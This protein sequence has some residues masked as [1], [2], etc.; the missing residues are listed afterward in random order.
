M[1]K[2]MLVIIMIA[3]ILC[4]CARN[5]ENE[6]REAIKQSQT[7]TSGAPEVKLPEP[8]TTDKVKAAFLEYINYRLYLYPVEI[9][10]SISDKQFDRYVGKSIDVEI[11]VYNN[12]QGKGVYVSTNVGEW[13]AV[14][15]EKKG[16]IYCDGLIGKN[17]QYKD[18]KIWP[19][20]LDEYELIEKYSV[21]VPE[22]RKPEYGKSER[23]DKMIAA[24][25]A[26]I[27]TTLLDSNTGEESPK[28]KNVVVYIA[29]FYEYENGAHAWLIRQD[30]YIA[31]YPVAFEEKDGRF[32]VIGCKG[33]HM[34]SINNFNE[35]GRFQYDRDIKDAVRQFKYNVKQ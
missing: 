22:A 29:D 7:A 17:D 25:E 23:K 16:F 13:L 24:F 30:G 18:K 28:W 1:K 20:N 11:R 9:M 32:K 21:V 34:D 15:N 3:C 33:Y 10:D 14:F 2:G 19:K 35:F 8:F 4:S 31:A 26:D 5:E 6:Q 27:K 12:P